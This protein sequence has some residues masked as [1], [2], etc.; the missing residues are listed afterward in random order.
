LETLVVEPGRCQFLAYKNIMIC[1]WIA[2]ADLA[3]AKA[4]ERAARIMARRYSTGRSFVAFILDGLAGPT[5]DAMPVFARLMA[6]GAELACMAYVL[7]GT[8]F[9]VSGLR[10][11]L[12]NAH[13]ESGAAARLKVGTSAD[14]IAEWLSAEHAS[15]TGVAI[16]VA[17]L[18]EV[19]RNAR[20]TPVA[21]RR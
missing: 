2:Q 18:Q 1:V 9:W 6:R 10:S 4:N 12:A 16:S 20:N 8:G 5:P 19:L 14:E 3:S 21:T 7:E 13:R 17:E 15:R 11:M